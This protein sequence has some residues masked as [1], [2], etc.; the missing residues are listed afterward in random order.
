[1]NIKEEWNRDI[2][3]AAI[4]KGV[5]IAVVIRLIPTIVPK[6]KI[7][8]YSVAQKGCGIALTINNAMA[9]LPASPCTKPTSKARNRGRRR[10]ATRV[11]AAAKTCS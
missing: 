2:R 4:V 8:R 6:Q 7:T 10:R 3:S 1:M 9:A 11:G 5:A